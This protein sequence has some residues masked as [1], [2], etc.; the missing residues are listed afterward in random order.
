MEQYAQIKKEKV[1]EKAIILMLF[2]SF[3]SP[4]FQYAMVQ[5]P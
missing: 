5:S 2:V 4:Q 3:P 1:R